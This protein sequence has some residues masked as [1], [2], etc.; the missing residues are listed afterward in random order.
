M[1]NNNLEYHKNISIFYNFFFIIPYFAQWI[2]L[3]LEF[4]S[5]LSVERLFASLTPIGVLTPRYVRN[6]KI[7]SLSNI[8]EHPQTSPRPHRC[9]R[10]SAG[11]LQDN[12]SRASANAKVTVGSANV[13]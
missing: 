7:R 10:D 1:S 3:I 6:K 8:K 11:A 2:F 9:V 5:D 13:V 12:Y 4:N